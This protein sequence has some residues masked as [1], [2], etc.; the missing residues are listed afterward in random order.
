MVISA[1]FARCSKIA[2]HSHVSRFGAPL[3]TAAPCRKVSVLYYDAPVGWSF[4]GHAI[5][6][7]FGQYCAVSNCAS[8]RFNIAGIS[9]SAV[10]RNKSNQVKFNQIGSDRRT[11]LQSQSQSQSQSHS[12]SLPTFVWPIVPWIALVVPARNNSA[13]FFQRS[14]AVSRLSVAIVNIQHR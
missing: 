9:Y 7:L 11:E 14:V 13:V 5:L 2:F 3:L 12:V 1:S 6:H 10:V 8:H 4:F